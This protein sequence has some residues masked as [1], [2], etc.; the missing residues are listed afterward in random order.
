MAGDIAGVRA[1]LAKLPPT[2]KMT[3]AERRAQY[4][5]AERFFPTPSDVKIEH[6]TAGTAAA[7]WLT[8]PGASADAAVLYLHGGGYVIGS[9]RSH[10][11][12]AA[13]IGRAANAPVLLPD[14][15]LAPE[16]PFPAAVDD[17][18]AA[19]RWL[20][21]RGIAPA[22]IAIA[23]DSAGG[24]LTVATLL[25]LRDAKV[26]LPGAGICIS[27]WTDMT[28]SAPSYTSRAEADPIVKVAGVSDMAK[29]YLGGKDPK[30]PLASPLFADLRGL[31][32]L[33][34]HVG[35]DE[36]LLDDATGLAKQARAA[37]VDVSLE[38][39]PKMIHVW[40]WFFPMLDEGQAAVDKIGDFVRTH[41]A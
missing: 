17:A 11:H 18:V 27:P 24:G 5:K 3:T 22:R 7:E 33:L 29:A 34:V 38:V 15:R 14:Y 2:D 37:G 21:G 9:P 26:P 39:W 31:P 41:T 36:V 32:P 1:H 19:Y 4:E 30:T 20:L 16:H 8:P 13:A 40:H 23:G 28:C 6:V 12:L 35:D 10:R 25:A